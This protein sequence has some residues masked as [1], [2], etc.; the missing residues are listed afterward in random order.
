MVVNENIYIVM[1]GPGF[2][3]HGGIVSV[4]REYF[5]AGL[6]DR[7]RLIFVP[8]LEAK[9]GPAIFIKAIILLLWL[10]L[11]HRPL[12]VH[13]HLSQKGSFVRKFIIFLG[14]KICSLKTVVHLHSS[15]FEEF[16]NAHA[17]MRG[18]AKFMFDHASRVLVLSEVWDKKLRLFSSNPNISILYNPAQLREKGQAIDDKTR[19]LF[20]GR[21]GQRKGVYDLLNCIA[22]NQNDFRKHRA[23]FILAGDGEVDHV[24]R[25]AHDTGISDLV[26]VPGWVAGEARERYLK[27]SDIFILPSYNEQMPM[28][29]LECMG[30][31]YPIIA[32]RIAGVPEMVTTGENGFLFAPGDARA[33]TDALIRLCHDSRLRQLMGRKSRQI[34]QEK[35][36]SK[37][38]VEQLVNIYERL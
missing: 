13:L 11:R 21:L 26:E 2:S 15:Q 4:V 38:I 9:R 33:M 37:L 28:S 19:V 30:Y 12:I 32:T 6:Q 31:G 20:M 35:F 16:M 14:A 8:T 22:Q 3:L 1:F 36:E 24:R 23:H 7:V 10:A 17:V 25:I 29:I 5:K 34:V 27:T 18:L